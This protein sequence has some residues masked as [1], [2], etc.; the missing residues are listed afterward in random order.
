[1]YLNQLL[2]SQN[3]NLDLFRVMAAL[4]VIYGHAPAFIADSNAADLVFNLLGFDY[5]AALAVK[6]FFMLSGLLV[7]QSLMLRPSLREFFV[8]RAVRI[9]PGLFCCIFITVFIVGPLFTQLNPFHYLTHAQ[10]WSYFFHNS[11]LISLQWTLPEVFTQGKSQVVNGSLWTLPLEIICYCCLA[12]LF[13]IVARWALWLA[14]ILLVFPIWICFFSELILPEQWLRFGE[15]LVL[16]GCFCVGVLFALN[17][18]VIHLSW[19]GV[20]LGTLGLILLW[21][22][23]GKEL[24]FYAVFFY[25]CLY[26]S[27]TRLFIRR[28]KLPGDPSYG[29]YI[30]GFLIQQILATLFPTSS[31]LFNQ[32]VAALLAIMLGFLSWYL[33]EK[34]AMK[35][36]RGRRH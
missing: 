7:T 16:G 22:S 33:I 29:I 8:K 12:L 31:I 18:R 24:C 32:V 21:E 17:Q 1:M 30:Y 5:S 34:P 20:V 25:V 13:F 15:S 35:L 9:F 2:L 14:S 36:V 23:P 4:L 3:N 27:G 28:L 26:L 11:I 19:K 6:F 10:T